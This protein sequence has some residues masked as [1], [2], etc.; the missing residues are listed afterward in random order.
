MVA[1]DDLVQG[2]RTF[3]EALDV[4]ALVADQTDRDEGGQPTAVGLR[5]D[6]RP[7]AADHLPVLEAP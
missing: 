6:D 7:V 1:L 3:L 4:L 5:V 2:A